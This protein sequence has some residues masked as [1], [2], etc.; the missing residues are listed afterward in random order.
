MEPR[1]RIAFLSSRAIN[2][3]ATAAELD[4]LC[5]LLQQYPDSELP[6]PLE[7]L[8]QTA[9]P[10]SYD[11]AHWDTIASRVGGG[12]PSYYSNCSNAPP[13]LDVGGGGHRFGHCRRKL[14]A[15]PAN[16]TRFACRSET[17]RATGNYAGRQ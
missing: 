13:S 12:R 1:E 2:E 16:S 15:Y 10:V 8:L 9:P 4:E 5:V 14:P 3:S 6:A 17:N 11:N 7:D